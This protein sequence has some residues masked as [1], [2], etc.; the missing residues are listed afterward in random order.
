MLSKAWAKWGP[1][2]N[3]QSVVYR[4]NEIVFSQ[5]KELS[6]ETGYNM[7]ESQKFML[8]EMKQM[9]KDKYYRTHPK[10]HIQKRVIHKKKKKK[11]KTD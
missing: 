2:L 6:T 8:S 1:Y 7:D 10:W 3:E 11:K 4:K 5:K 9:R